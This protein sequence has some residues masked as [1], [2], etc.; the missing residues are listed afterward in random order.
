MR[1]LKR[2]LLGLLAV[3]VLLL[4]LAAG[5]VVA[6]NSEVGR[7]FAVREINKYGA[8]YIHLSGLGG[9]F[10]A[11]IKLARFEVMDPKGAWLSGQQVELKWSPLA[12]L[13]GNVSVQAL[14]AQSIDMTRSPA[15]PAGKSKSSGKS[16]LP[17]WRLNLDKLEI[18]TLRIAPSL[19]G[20][21]VALHVIGST[22][23]RDAQHGNITLDATTPDGKADYL[24]SATLDPRNVA[25]KLYVNEPPDGLI[26]HFSGPDVRLPLTMKVALSG[27][28]DAA[29]LSAALAL[30]AAK[31]NMAGTLGLD[32]NHPFAD[33]TLTVPALA[34][35][36]NLAKQ[37][38]S[39]ETRLHL[40]VKQTGKKDGATLALKGHVELTQAPAGLDKLLSGRT[41]LSI[42][43]SLQGKKVTL[44]QVA[45]D[46]PQFSLNGHGTLDEKRIDL[47]TDAKLDS[48]AT[49]APRLT[50]AVQLH[51]H[52]AGNP[53]D[54]TADADLTGNVTVPDVPS[55]PFKVTLHATHLPA[56]PHG[57]LT[58]TG[59]LAGAPLVLDAAFSRDK[60][61][62]ASVKLTK[63]TWKS[64][65]AVA[66]LNLAA[67]A[68]LPTGTASLTLGALSDFDVFTGTRMRGAAKADFA[69]QDDQALKLD[70]WAKDVVA[71]PSVGA[72]NGTVSAEG[73]LDALAV[74]A[75]AT[76]ARLISYPARLKLAGVV[77]APARSAH[78]TRLDAVW[79][80]LNA[81]LRG[82]A[83][84]V[85]KPDITVRH[86]D[87]ALDKASIALDG[88]LSPEMKVKAT[89]RNLDLGLAKLF[90]PSLDA[91][92]IVNLTADVTGT[93][94]APGGTVTLNATGLRYISKSTE[95]LPAANLSGTAKLNGNS[96]DVN[97]AARAGQDLDLT[98]RGTAPLTMTGPMKLAVSG[99]VNLP[100]LNP[101]LAK[102]NT[103]LS[104]L[105]TTDMQLAGTPKAPTGRITLSAQKLK[106]ESGPAASL[107]PANINATAQLKGR[108]TGL[109]LSVKAGP[110]VNLTLNGTAPLNM[111]GP[112]D[113]TLAG[114]L[115]L[116]LLDPLLTA[117][118]NLVRGVVTTN[119][120][121]SGTPRGPRANGSLKLAK[122]MVQNIAS[123]LN[124]TDISANIAAAD[125]LITL[126]SLSATAGQGKIT[127][128]GTINLGNP[129][130]PVNLAL[131][132]DHA[133][134]IASDLLTETLNAALTLRGG[135]KSAS[136]LGGS[137]HILKAN[138]NI[139]KSL[140][141][142]VANLPIHDASTAPTA[143]K[144]SA[145][146]AP[147]IH[148]ALDVQAQNQ[149]FI[150][151]D[152][153]FAELG[154]DLKL[155]GT[156]ANPQP[157]GGF[158][159]IRGNF[160]LAG[161]TLQ[162]TSGSIAFNGG[163]FIPALDLEATTN[164]SDNGTATL[165]IGGTASKPK[166]TLTSSP[167]L[168]SDEILAQLLFAQ[169]ASSLSPFQAAS[170]AAA[171]AQ[172]SG[173]GGGFSPLDSV[174]NALGLDQLS[175]GSSGSGAPSV[176]AGRYVAPGVYVGASQSTSGAGT[177]AN[178]EINLY[179]GLKLQSSTGTDSTGQDSSSV[180]LS[181]QFN[182]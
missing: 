31:L 72:V 176:E 135:L 3:L 73:K 140:P 143:P 76:I 16:S 104:G 15:Y 162:F 117:S 54:F 42:L 180:G 36:G 93:P 103:K 83:D 112:M 70:V 105:V 51:S 49:L 9:H 47:I 4:V 56:M 30:G 99:R 131:N 171:L 134:P 116:K 165:I 132:A 181:Y 63:A 164:T 115:N 90:E 81:R 169:S 155:G 8:D 24:L 10:P 148:L 79:H 69:Y 61:G 13:R 18:G 100:V 113:L 168:P 145:P 44:G 126:Q 12:L 59:T 166:I 170:L 133:T 66:D 144:A 17:A 175:L 46:G 64:L 153:L 114:H 101:V 86:L 136:T 53:Q 127:G 154:G 107:P 92:G 5:L 89:V 84:I 96:A 82:P 151:G 33:V 60:T 80:G 152:G 177:K 22:H 160:S 77:D 172:I 34:P 167:P 182:Y 110:N 75:D 37:S 95:G 20:E 120:R 50:G 119:M 108:S 118:G 157:S 25:M 158:K 48:L 129:T 67:G 91:A 156:A 178:V 2:I 125:K 52:V 55:G 85:T 21:A 161:K 19:A 38:L 173:V 27:P 147:P 124:L 94:K 111:T 123:G 138:I 163:G 45:L 39:G 35:F 40:V 174:R 43:A 142:S 106:D 109:N 87:L 26:G 32:P 98:A 128:H 28:R 139:P 6:L 146:P 97:L 121:V 65:D 23:L 14:T 179:K 149:I 141:A 29:N 58:G 74:Q 150:R 57:T 68:K 7:Q 159:L 11:D 137:I 130:L 122:G 78:V 62:A 1:W 102:M 88:T 71:T 41:D